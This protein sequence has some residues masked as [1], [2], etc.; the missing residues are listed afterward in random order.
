MKTLFAL[1]S[2]LFLSGCAYYQPMGISSTSVGSQYERPVGIGEGIARRWYFFPC[3]SLCPVGED[4]LKAAMEDALAGSPGDTLANVYVDRRTIYFPHPMLPLIVRNDIVVTGTLI[5]YNTKEFPPDNEQ[6]IDFRK[7]YK[8]EELWPKLLA[9]DSDAQP[10]VIS[11]LSNV[12][13]SNLKMFLEGKEEKK[14]IKDG[15]KEADLFRMV[16]KR[17]I[18]SQKPAE[19]DVDFWSQPR[20]KGDR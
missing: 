6:A 17:E 3:W 18:Y 7:I 8:S 4:S 9:L 11:K 2:V 13:L 5:K 20:P 14:E 16:L 12:A 19:Y 10:R 1:L 15:T